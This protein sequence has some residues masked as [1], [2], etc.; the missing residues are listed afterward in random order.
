MVGFPHRIVT[1]LSCPEI[2]DECL[3]HLE[4]TELA[5]CAQVCLSW[6]EPA[7][8]LI[9]ETIDLRKD[10]QKLDELQDNPFRLR[11]VRRIIV[12]IHFSFTQLVTTPMRVKTLE[13]RIRHSLL[14]IGPEYIN[15]T[16]SA[17]CPNLET[18]TIGDAVP[19]L[20]SSFSV[21]LNTLGK[22]KNLRNLTLPAPAIPEY[23][24][25]CTEDGAFFQLAP[26]TDIRPQLR[27]LQLVSTEDRDNPQIR[28]VASRMP[29]KASEYSWLEEP[30]CPFDVRTLRVLVIGSPAATQIIL[31]LVSHSLCRLE[32]CQAFD[33]LSSWTQYASPIQLLSLRHLVLAFHLLPSKWLLDIIRTP[34]IETITIKWTTGVPYSCYEERLRQMDG[35]ISRLDA[36]HVFP[37]HLKRIVFITASS[38]PDAHWGLQIF[39]LSSLFGTIISHQEFIR[40]STKNWKESG[41]RF[42]CPLRGTEYFLSQGIFKEVVKESYDY[43]LDIDQSEVQSAQEESRASANNVDEAASPT[44]IHQIPPEL[45]LKIFRIHIFHH[46][47]K[48]T[49]WAGYSLQIYCPPVSR[50]LHVQCRALVLAGA[51]SRWREIVLAEHIFWSTFYLDIEVFRDR[52]QLLPLLDTYTSNSRSVP[53]FLSIS[54]DN[55]MNMDNTVHTTVNNNIKQVLKILLEHAKRWRSLKFTAADEMYIRHLNEWCSLDCLVSSGYSKTQLS[56]VVFLSLEDLQVEYLHPG[57]DRF[58]LFQASPRLKKYSVNFMSCRPKLALPDLSHLEEFHVIE[59]F[60]EGPSI[61]YLLSQMPLLRDCTV[62]GFL[63]THDDLNSDFKPMASDLLAACP[64]ITN[65]RLRIDDIEGMEHFKQTTLGLS[66]TSI[67]PKLSSLTVHLMVYGFRRMGSQSDSHSVQEQLVDVLCSLVEPRTFP[68]LRHFTLNAV[69]FGNYDQHFWSRLRLTGR[70]KALK[71]I[72][73]STS[74]LRAE[75]GNH[76]VVSDI[77]VSNMGNLY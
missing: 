3:L 49:P 36:S 29:F 77:I 73:N 20:Y 18:F 28:T 65:L 66:R 8:A 32:V 63:S 75:D 46:S 10:G 43:L 69:H 47:G 50:R 40:R 64:P 9:F 35:Q 12:N 5:A 37:P 42:L 27:F 67:A 60:L 59:G 61:G 4:E 56:D 24:R 54:L 74:T 31:P 53:L 25:D 14:E 68:F 19:L 11:Y 13:F 57:H 58:S 41:M 6:G 51:C 7:K 34:K 52:P 22:C 76:I 17:F 70:L 15:E 16:I 55:T 62:E 33:Q 44:L 26:I 21:V 1:P 39:P 71:V 23:H 30:T 48:D 38:P 2:L 72:N 45:L